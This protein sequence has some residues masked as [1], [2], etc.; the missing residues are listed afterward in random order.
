[1]NYY[2]KIFSQFFYS[3]IN[4]IKKGSIDVENYVLADESSS[5]I[6]VKIYWTSSWNFS[7]PIW[8]LKKFVRSD[9]YL[10]SFYCNLTALSGV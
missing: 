6:L 5:Y 9:L 10:K 4:I 2:V 1:M 8:F 3:I 7:L